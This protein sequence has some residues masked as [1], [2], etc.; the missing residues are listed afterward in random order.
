MEEKRGKASTILR[1]FFDKAQVRAHWRGQ[2][3]KYKETKSSLRPLPKRRTTHNYSLN[4]T[5]SLETFCGLAPLRLLICGGDGSVGWVLREI[6]NL[7]LK[8]RTKTRTSRLAQK[9]IS[10]LKRKDGESA[11]QAGGEKKEKGNAP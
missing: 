2:L 5:F 9:V 1:V 8:V 7:Q 4:V 11:K 10:R 3:R 6:D